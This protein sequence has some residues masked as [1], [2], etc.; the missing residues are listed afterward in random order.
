[1]KVGRINKS[2]DGII[3]D[4]NGEVQTL[5]AGHGN[6]PKILINEERIPDAIQ[7]RHAANNSG[8]GRGSM[9]KKHSWDMVKVKSATKD[10]FEEAKVGDSINLSNPNSKTRRGRVGVGVGVGVAQT[11][12]TQAN[13]SVLLEGN[14]RRLTEI[15]CE[16]L[17]GFKDNHTKFGN[18]DS[19]I[20]EISRTQ[21]YKMC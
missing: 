17:Q 4:I 21:R 18:Y 14:I 12:D 8:G 3:F 5:S 13:Q 16:R 6:V 15:E 20:R 7:S 19:G 9:G 1:M 2:Q 10:G 11:L